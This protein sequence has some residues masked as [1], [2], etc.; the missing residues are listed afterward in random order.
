MYTEVTY[1][2]AVVGVFVQILQDIM[3]EKR[4]LLLQPGRL[5]MQTQGHNRITSDSSIEEGKQNY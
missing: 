4:Q 3:Y 5:H 1:N 2:N